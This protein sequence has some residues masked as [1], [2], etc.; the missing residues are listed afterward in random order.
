MT[1]CVTYSTFIDKR[2]ISFLREMAVRYK[3]KAG[4]ICIGILGEDD[5]DT[6]GLNDIIKK[7]RS[8]GYIIK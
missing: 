5:L 6:E 8:L 4:N 1:V 7:I 2:F 3:L